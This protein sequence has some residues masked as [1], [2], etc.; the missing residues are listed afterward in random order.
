[1]ILALATRHRV[2]RPAISM[3]GG[4]VIS[5]GAALPA[6]VCFVFEKHRDKKNPHSTKCGFC[7]LKQIVN[8]SHR[9][10]HL[11]SV[12]IKICSN[13]HNRRK[14]LFL[15]RGKVILLRQSGITRFPRCASTMTSVKA[16]LAAQLCCLISYLN[17]TNEEKM[18]TI[19]PLPISSC[20][21]PNCGNCH[22]FLSLKI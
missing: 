7:R 3:E 19:L 16:Y 20:R 13:V 14:Q 9:E 18:P 12:G 6:A 8:A 5:Y 21:R 22:Y 11:Q 1:M 4:T 10:T 17:H 15:E 2:E